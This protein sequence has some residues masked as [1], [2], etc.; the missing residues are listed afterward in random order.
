MSNISITVEGSPSVTRTAVATVI[1]NSLIEKGFSN[2]E[3]VD[4]IGEPVAVGE[5]NTILDMAIAANPH[6]FTTN[7]TVMEKDIDDE[8][9]ACDDDDEQVIVAADP[10]MTALAESM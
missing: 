7:I 2:V 9:L 10:A 8:C 3:T 4:E 6:V 1:T 5:L